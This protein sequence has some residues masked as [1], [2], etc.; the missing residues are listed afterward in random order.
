MMVPKISRRRVKDWWWWKWLKA[1]SFKLSIETAWSKFDMTQ[2]GLI[3]NIRCMFYSPLELEKSLREAVCVDKNLFFFVV[4]S[5]QSSSCIPGWIITIM[6]HR[7]NS[8]FI[9]TL[10]HGFFFFLIESL[11][12][13]THTQLTHNVI[14]YL[15]FAPTYFY[16]WT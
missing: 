6:I 16:K 9:Q 7:H 5:L 1:F 15:N 14:E 4:I 8:I 3:L 12:I 10:K 13:P 2:T 11:G